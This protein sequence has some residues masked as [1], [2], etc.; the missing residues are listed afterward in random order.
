M[1]EVADKPES[2]KDIKSL[3]KA[4]DINVWECEKPPEAYRTLNDFFARKLKEGPAD[5][6]QIET[7]QRAEK[8]WIK[9]NDFSIHELL[10]SAYDAADWEHATLVISRLSPTDYHRMH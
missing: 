9:G 6:R 7:V 5:S 2:A 8:L 10:G 3:I 4:Y 1:K